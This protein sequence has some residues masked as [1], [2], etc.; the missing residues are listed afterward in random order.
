[1]PRV[2]DRVGPVVGGLSALCLLTSCTAEAAN[3]PPTAPL[4]ATPATE[5][6]SRATSAATTEPSATPTEVL[7]ERV[8]TVIAAVPRERRRSAT[9]ASLI[10]GTATRRNSD[11]GAV[12]PGRYRLTVYC[13]GRG[14]VEM[15][16]IVTG[17]AVRKSLATC[18]PELAS[19]SIDIT[20][21]ATGSGLVTDLAIRGL[22]EVAVGYV[23]TRENQT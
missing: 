8:S 11:D 2:T 12:S 5:T 15:T 3:Q 13:A 9:D 17:I 6:G 14:S 20:A 4:A 10:R 7:L 16:F 1:M 19:D 21:T 18:T 22:P 23:V